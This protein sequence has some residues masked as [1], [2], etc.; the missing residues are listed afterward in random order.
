[1]S[2]RIITPKLCVFCY[3]GCTTNPNKPLI[4]IIIIIIITNKCCLR[5]L[6]QEAFK[7]SL[8]LLLGQVNVLLV[9]FKDSDLA[10]GLMETE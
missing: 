5:S 8:S 6:K 2:S 10:K 9:V 3:A 7:Q 4:I 1:M